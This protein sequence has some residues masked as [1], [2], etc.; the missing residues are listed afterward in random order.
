MRLDKVDI[1]AMQFENR[2]MAIF[3]E[4]LQ[5]ETF[6]QMF[7]DNSLEEIEVI[8]SKLSKYAKTNLI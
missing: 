5:D 3:D 8:V 6:F 4:C 7:V 1:V 2:T